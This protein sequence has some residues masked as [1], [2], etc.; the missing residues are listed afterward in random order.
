MP[1][2]AKARAPAK[3]VMA[4]SREVGSLGMREAIRMT[5]DPGNFDTFGNEEG[6]TD[7]V[8]PAVLVWSMISKG[9]ISD[10]APT[11]IVVSSRLVSA[12]SAL[13]QS[14]R[15]VACGYGSVPSDV[16]SEERVRDRRE[17]RPVCGRQ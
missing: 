7:I 8:D 16:G 2:A 15:A 17:R 9:S 11:R 4:R 3:R 13:M 5:N 14:G 1:T 12:G 6:G 10:A